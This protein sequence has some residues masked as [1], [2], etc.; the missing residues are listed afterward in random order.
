MPFSKFH[1]HTRWQTNISTNKMRF[2]ALNFF[3][4]IF[5]IECTECNRNFK[6]NHILISRLYQSACCASPPFW[7]TF[8]VV[9]CLLKAMPLV[10]KS[11]YCIL[12]ITILPLY[13][14]L[15]V[16]TDFMCIFFIPRLWR[17]TMWV[18]IFT[19]GSIWFLAINSRVQLQWRPLIPST[20]TSTQIS[21]M[22]RVW[23]T[24]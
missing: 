1:Q 24:R 11:Y 9:I 12:R 19:C 17:A 3:S 10:S 7:S 20:L 15:D 4:V 2:L 5:K 22:P 6:C 14:F 21:M 16:G 23:R 13:C 8:K 18:Q